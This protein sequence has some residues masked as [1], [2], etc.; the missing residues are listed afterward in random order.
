MNQETMDMFKTLTEFPAAPGFERE[1]RAYVKNAMSPYTDEFV[2]D[3]LGSLFGV[4]RGAENGP[5]IMVAG[6]FDEVGFMVT[7]ITPGGM[8]RFTP[9]GGW[10][11]SAVASQR[12]Q[13]ITPDRVLDGVV[14]STP[15]HLLSPEER[16]K[17]GDISKMYLDI[18]ADS[19]EEAESFGVKPGQQILPVCPFTPLANPKKIMAKAWDNRYGVGLALE[20]VKALHD[21]QLPNTVYAGAT[22]QEEVGLRGA[23]TAAN[24]LNPDIFFGLDASAASDMTGDR[25]AFGQ[26]GQGALLRIYDPTMITHRGLIEYVQDTADTHKIK[27]QYFVS[28]GGTDAGAVHTSGIG[29][30]SAV[31][32]ICSRYIHTASSVIHSDDYEAAKELLIKLVEGLDRTTLQTILENS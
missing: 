11:A 4:L 24:L 27:Y 17:T 20:L 15:I 28:Q 14:G 6:H 19:K 3:R 31:I 32:G 7:G 12:L 22:V 13:I 26:L 8:I 1:L 10:L 21:K 2:Q 9:L 23:R 30:P 5:K 25:Q 18:G 29:V 16:T